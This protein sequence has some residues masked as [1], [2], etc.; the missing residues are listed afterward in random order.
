[1]TCFTKP[2]R[3]RTAYQTS[4]DHM[5]LQ[6]S[7][8]RQMPH[9]LCIPV[10]VGR[11]PRHR[12]HPSKTGTLSCTSGDFL[13]RDRQDSLPDKSF[14]A[15]AIARHM[16]PPCTE[17]PGLSRKGQALTVA[18]ASAQTLFPCGL[19]FSR[20]PERTEHETPLPTQSPSPNFYRLLS[21]VSC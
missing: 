18:T 20:P 13:V 11:S 19:V 2:T 5:L 4:C 16:P 6:S 14:C 8:P 12:Q 17:L 3:F 15:K 21:R 10:P 1:M 7:L 9:L